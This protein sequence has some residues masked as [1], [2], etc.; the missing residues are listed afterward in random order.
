MTD[1]DARPVSLNKNLTDARRDMD[2]QVDV[3]PTKL[4]M[5]MLQT[6]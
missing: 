1:P 6:N 3:L 5:Q 4:H 2:S